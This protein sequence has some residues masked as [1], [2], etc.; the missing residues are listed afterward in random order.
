MGEGLNK[1]SISE[2]AVE[3]MAPMSGVVISAWFVAQSRIL[4][5]LLEM[6]SR[7]CLSRLSSPKCLVAGLTVFALMPSGAGRSPSY[8]EAITVWMFLI[9][10]KCFHKGLI[11][12]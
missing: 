9:V 3:G 12:H 2:A 10:R 11:S 4:G 7:T 5:S 8:K 6:T 1:T